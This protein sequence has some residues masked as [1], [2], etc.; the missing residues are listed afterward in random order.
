[1]SLSGAEALETFSSRPHDFDLI[2]T[3]LVM[4]KMTG[5]DLAREIL[6]IRP[7]IPV[8]VITGFTEK[9]L[10]KKAKTVGVREIIAKP[11]EIRTLANAMRKALDEG[12]RAKG[13]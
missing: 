6:S 8:I 10:M 13:G 7:D 11:V 1:M 12:R 4:P 3:D 9:K 5:V 2:M